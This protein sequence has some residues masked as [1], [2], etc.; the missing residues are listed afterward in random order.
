[1]L[2][3]RLRQEA[4]YWWR[5]GELW[6]ASRSDGEQVVIACV[7]ILLLLMLIIRMSMRGKDPGGTSRQFG[8][9]ILMVTV[10]AFGLGWMLDSGAGTLGFIFQ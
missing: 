7:F 2:L 6:F 10:F 4:H 8:S 3:R 9:S 5:E 1:M